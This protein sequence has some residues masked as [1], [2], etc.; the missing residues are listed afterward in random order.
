MPDLSIHHLIGPLLRDGMISREEAPSIYE[1]LRDRIDEVNGALFPLT[2]RVLIDR[3][4]GLAACVTIPA[5]ELERYAEERGLHPISPISERARLSYF[6]SVVAL[7]FRRLG[8]RGEGRPDW[9]QPDRVYEAIAA[10]LPQGMEHDRASQV[11]RLSSILRK[12]ETFRLVEAR[13][14]RDGAEYRASRYLQIAV[15]ASEV[16]RFERSVSARLKS[17]MTETVPEPADAAEP[18]LFNLEGAT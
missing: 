16:D 1:A 12:L 11:S 8:D 2:R 3:D 7:H 18:D 13:D 5:E 14:G 15:P 9:V 6:E 17:I 10:L 4:L